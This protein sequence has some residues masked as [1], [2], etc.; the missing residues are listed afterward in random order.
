MRGENLNCEYL[1]ITINLPPPSFLELET[2]NFYKM[3]F[4]Q[5]KRL[6]MLQ[7]QNLKKYIDTKKL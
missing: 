6:R 3:F 1:E 7:F 5:F 2:S 4:L